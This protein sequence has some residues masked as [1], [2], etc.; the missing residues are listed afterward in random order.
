MIK[1]WPLYDRW[2]KFLTRVGVVN[3]DCLCFHVCTPGVKLMTFLLLCH[4]RTA[5]RLDR[6]L[7]DYLPIE[8]VLPFH[9]VNKAKHRWHLI[10][11]FDKNVIPVTVTISIILI[12]LNKFIFAA[13]CT[14][15]VC[16][17][18]PNFAFLNAFMHCSRPFYSFAKQ[19]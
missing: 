1:K 7:Y 17:F 14:A 11:Y 3:E 9:L 10:F 2:K 4:L 15:D 8:P 16:D 12:L 19:F 5:D 6:K 13:S 18:E